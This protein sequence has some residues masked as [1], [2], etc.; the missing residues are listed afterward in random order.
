MHQTIYCTAPTVLFVLSL[1]G[2]LAGAQTPSTA[3]SAR[4]AQAMALLKRMA[5]FIS[6]T[7]HF[8]VMVD[9]GFDV[10]Q[11]SGQKLEFGETRKIVV[12]FQPGPSFGNLILGDEINRAPA[13]CRPRY[14]NGARLRGLGLPGGRSRAA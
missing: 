5:D 6:Q 2:T 12:R 11:D 8:S 4:D 9:T 14:S 7:Q 1:V 3:A 13:K 10:V